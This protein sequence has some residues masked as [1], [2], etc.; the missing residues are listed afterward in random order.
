[1]ESTSAHQ[2]ESK[3]SP[4]HWWAGTA[5]EMHLQ[6]TRGVQMGTQHHLP[7]DHRRNAH[8]TTLSTLWAWA[9]GTLW[10]LTL[11]REEYRG[12]GCWQPQSAA[13][14]GTPTTD[15]RATS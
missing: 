9:Q 12:P 2:A 15:R 11:S 13:T 8:E 7:E 5:A 4:G 1:M 6:V 14:G 3:Q 10:L